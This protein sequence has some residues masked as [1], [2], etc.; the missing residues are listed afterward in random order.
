MMFSIT[1]IKFN[2]YKCCK[3]LDIIITI[4]IIQ[5]MVQIKLSLN[6]NKIII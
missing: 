6:N 5:I 2:N 3:I 4:I 1:I